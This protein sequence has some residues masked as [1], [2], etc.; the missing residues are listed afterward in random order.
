MFGFESLNTRL[1]NIVRQGKVSKIYPERHSA[2]VTFE[3]KGG[4]VSSEM[5]ILIPFTN[6]N[7]MY[8]LPDIGDVVVCLMQSNDLS[9]GGGF[10]I[11]SLY[12]AENPPDQDCYEDV[13]KLEFGDKTFLQYDRRTHEFKLHFNDDAEVSYDGQNHQ[14]QI[15]FNDKSEITFDGQNSEL[16]INIKGNIMINGDKRLEIST[17]EEIDVESK[18]DIEMNGR[19][20]RLN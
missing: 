19:N 18:A 5:P 14:F 7:K 12:T 11:G 20:I 6:K 17:K 10:I 16:T 9:G 13:L 3:D 4:L 15:K 2:R 8:C 1:S